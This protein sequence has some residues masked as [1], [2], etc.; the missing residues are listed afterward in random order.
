MERSSRGH[1]PFAICTTL[2]VFS[3]QMECSTG[4]GYLAEPATPAKYDR[5]VTF[6]DN[7]MPTDCKLYFEFMHSFSIIIASTTILQ[8]YKYFIP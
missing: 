7:N 8:F 5:L 3:M 1:K 6:I 2:N 4:G